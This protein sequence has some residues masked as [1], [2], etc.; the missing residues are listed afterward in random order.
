MPPKNVKGRPPVTGREGGHTITSAVTIGPDAVPIVRDAGMRRASAAWT[1]ADLP[2]EISARIV[3]H[4]VSGCWVWTGRTDRDG[5]GRYRGEGVHRYVYKLLVGE[6]PPERPQLDHVAALGC[7]FRSCCNLGHLQPSTVRENVLRGRSFAAL[8]AA[9]IRCG[10]CRR[11]YDAE[12]TYWYKGRR[13][14][15]ACIRR[16]VAEYKRRR[17]ALARAA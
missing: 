13:D 5:Y 6:I 14:C 16:R 3:V 11:P 10:A 17:T 12:N 1:M 4:P 15:R 8:N 7:L 2:P 9:K